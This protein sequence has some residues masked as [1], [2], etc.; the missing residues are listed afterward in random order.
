MFCPLSVIL[1][2]IVR[3][4]TSPFRFGAQNEAAIFI[5]RVSHVCFCIASVQSYIITKTDK[6]GQ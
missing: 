5:C 3:S 4:I 1:Y 6:T 2:V